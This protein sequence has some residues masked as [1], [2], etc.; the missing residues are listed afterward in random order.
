M[1]HHLLLDIEGLNIRFPSTA[2]PVNAVQNLSLQ[3]HSG[4]TLGIVG[5]SG[6]GKSVTGLSIMGLLPEAEV[7]GTLNFHRKNAEKQ[8]APD[9]SPALSEPTNLLRL[10]SKQMYPIRG[11][12]I[13]MIFQ[14]P[15]TSLNPVLRCGD[16]VVEAIRL[17]QPLSYAA[18]KARALALFDRVKLSDNKRIFR[19]FPHEL[20][21]GQKQRVMI[22]MAMSGQPAL[23]IADEPTTALDVTVQKAILDLMREWREEA[24]L[25]MLFISHDLGVIAEIADRV[26]VM[27]QGDIVETGPVD[28]ILRR[29]EHPYT[30]GLVA[31]RP[32]LRHKLHRL[33]TIADFFEKESFAARVITAKETE[34]RHTDLYAHTPLVKALNLSFR[35]PA[36]KN[37]LG[38][39]TA[40]LN[41]VD[42]LSFDIFPGEVFG[43]AGESGCG[44]TTLGRIIG[45]LLPPYSG[46]LWYRGLP[47]STMNAGNL[48]PL[49]REIQLVF[50]D[51]YASLNP[52]MTIGQALLE[53]LIAHRL[54]AN[55]RQRKE[56]IAELLEIVGL[57][58]DHARRYPREF[59]GGQRQRICLARSLSLQP[60]LL[61]CDEI[62]SALDVSV[63]ATVLN[64]LMD[65]QQQF[66]LTSLFISHDLSVIKQMCDRVLVMNQGR[67]EEIG[68]PDQLYEQPASAY[69]RNLIGAIPG[70]PDKR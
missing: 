34:R 3:L 13:A 18:A 68:Y 46:E 50:Q 22:A 17:H 40:W 2:G 49:R 26:A 65:L 42:Q 31:C 47:V 23:L 43:L 62:V 37:V 66:G 53:P 16:Q 9:S 61:I 10:T 20:S 4:E 8:S 28:Q 48:Q 21:G 57:E 64:L 58:A 32:S 12:E 55:D 5:E 67:L 45:H 56:K 14:E 44:K 33:P 69:V 51:P 7:T 54:Y 59:S 29:P 41:A 38:F 19:A 39:P 36:K 63:Q 6:S 52:R 60:K 30:K 25:S 15:M 35:Y 70:Q 24:G 1:N 11:A 27:Q